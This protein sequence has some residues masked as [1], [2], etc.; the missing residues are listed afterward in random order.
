MRKIIIL[1]RLFV[2]FP[3]GRFAPFIEYS[4]LGALRD[5]YS[6]RLHYVDRIW[7]SLPLTH[8]GVYMPLTTPARYSEWLDGAIT[9]R[10]LERGPLRDTVLAADPDADAQ[11][12]KAYLA[13][14]GAPAMPLRQFI[15]LGGPLSFIYAVTD[16]GEEMSHRE[17]GKEFKDIAGM[18]YPLNR[19][20]NA[21]ITET[22]SP[23][24]FL[25]KDYGL[26]GGQYGFCVSAVTDLMTAEHGPDD[27]VF[28]VSAEDSFRR[29]YVKGLAPLRL[30]TAPREALRIP[31]AVMNEH[32]Y[33]LVHNI[34]LPENPAIASLC[35][36]PAAELPRE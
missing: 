9:E 17:R 19:F 16:P 6:G 21:M 1:R 7:K 14:D 22:M 26:S 20:W 10:A 8:N 2:L 12:V 23:E 34:I 33:T 28:T 27:R 32:Y 11:A 24:Y 3:D 13:Y 31:Q 29:W 30:T 4:H 18:K 36:E 25:T 15:S 5:P 35:D